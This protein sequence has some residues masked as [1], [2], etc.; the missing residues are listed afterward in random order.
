MFIKIYIYAV[1][2][3]LISSVLLS[4]GIEYKAGR[5]ESVYSWYYSTV[6]LRK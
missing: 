4:Y 6:L 5:I 3:L 2:I 1:V